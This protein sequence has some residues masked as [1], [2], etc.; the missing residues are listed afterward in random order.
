LHEERERE[1]DMREREHR[2]DKKRGER[3]TLDSRY[4]TVAT[5]ELK[6]RT[7]IKNYEL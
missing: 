5:V 4:S 3:M 7:K 1:R 6:I 2:P